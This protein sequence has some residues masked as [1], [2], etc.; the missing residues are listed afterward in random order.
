MEV[1]TSRKDP[2]RTN[3]QYGKKVFGKQAK[4]MEEKSENEELAE[5]IQKAGIEVPGSANIVIRKVPCFF[6]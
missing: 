6:G 5:F 4:K 1:E 3:E 2:S